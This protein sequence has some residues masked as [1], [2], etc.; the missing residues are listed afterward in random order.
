MTGKVKGSVPYCLQLYNNVNLRL[1]MGLIHICSVVFFPAETKTV[2]LSTVF[3][4]SKSTQQ[5]SFNCLRQLACWMIHLMA[6]QAAIFTK[7]LN[8]SGSVKIFPKRLEC[9]P[10]VACMCFMCFYNTHH[11][12]NKHSAHD[13]T[14]LCLPCFY[15]IP[16][17]FSQSKFL[18]VK[19]NTVEYRR[20]WSNPIWC[21]N[22]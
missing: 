16:M 17:T 21:H 22:L 7:S 14:S 15:N 20:F 4:L 3:P 8:I 2:N 11:D 12:W 5:G 1:L 19:I 13:W 6:A 10:S 9:W 18:P